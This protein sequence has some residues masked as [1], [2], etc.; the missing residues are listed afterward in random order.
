MTDNN[1]TTG[2]DKSYSWLQRN[3]MWIFCGLI[4]I[5][6]VSPWLLTRSWTKIDFSNTGQIGD[7]IGGLTAPFINLLSAVLVYLAFKEQIESNNLTRRQFHLQ[8]IKEQQRGQRIKQLILWDLSERI[9][10]IALEIKAEVQ[11]YIPNIT[12]GKIIPMVDHV[13][14]NKDIFSA[15]SMNDYFEVFSKEP[16]DLQTLANFYNRVEFIYS[17]I[18]LHSYDKLNGDRL[19]AAKI[20]FLDTPQKKAY[21]DSL[22]DRYTRTM[23][24][25]VANIDS[26]T[27]QID[28]FVGKYS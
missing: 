12:P 3:S 7:T 16:K 25:L 19:A 9:K 2:S 26:L 5:A 23:T 21:H 22:N 20:M 27:Q 4:I 10:P 18:P 11:K 15:N 8:E 17:N 1:Q 13:D 24:S 6:F 28:V 14:F